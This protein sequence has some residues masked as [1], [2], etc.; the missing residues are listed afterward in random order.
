MQCLETLNEI[1]SAHYAPATQVESILSQRHVVEILETVGAACRAFPYDQ[2][3]AKSAEKLVACAYLL[4]VPVEESSAIAEGDASVTFAPSPA[5][6]LCWRRWFRGEHGVSDA[7][8][9]NT[10]DCHIAAASIELAVADSM[11]EMTG[12]DVVQQAARLQEVILAAR[13]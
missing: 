2:K 5:P 7:H 11:V 6:H 3:L 9:V 8:F 12:W 13:R 1:C 4:Q 10:L